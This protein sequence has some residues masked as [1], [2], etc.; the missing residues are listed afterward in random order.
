MTT[1]PPPRLGAPLSGRE[2]D[3]LDGIARGWV[4]AELAAELGLSPDTVKTHAQRMRAKLGARDNAHAVGIGMRAGIIGDRPVVEEQGSRGPRRMPLTEKQAE[5]LSLAADGASLS[6][7]AGRMGVTRERVSSL[8]STAYQRLDVA[9]L[10][11]DLKRPAAVR[12]ARKRG[13]IPGR[14]EHE[15]PTT[16]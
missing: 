15:P 5:A 8:L 12:I 11:R 10:P 2:V 13:L 7:V 6:E 9:H 4:Y 1:L 16:P 3:V 14:T